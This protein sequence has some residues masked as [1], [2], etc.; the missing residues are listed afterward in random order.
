MTRSEANRILN[1]AK[2]GVAMSQQ[3]INEA[4]TTT[5]DLGFSRLSGS[6]GE[7]LCT[8][9]AESSDFGAC[10]VES[11]RDAAGS[12]RHMGWSRYLNQATIG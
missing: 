7:P 4:L 12:I 2:Q 9:G 1:S 10:K 5:G 3:L 6:P 11:F 8:D